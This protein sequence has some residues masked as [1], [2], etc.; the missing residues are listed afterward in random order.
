MQPASRTGP[1]PEDAPLLAAEEAWRQESFQSNGSK[2]T[3][4]LHGS[5]QSTG[6]QA[7]QAHGQQTL[8]PWVLLQSSQGPDVPGLVLPLCVLIETV[9][10]T[11]SLYAI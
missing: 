6:R 3:R 2:L 4:N 5:F 7:G 10:Q 1:L 11:L 8:G 9:D